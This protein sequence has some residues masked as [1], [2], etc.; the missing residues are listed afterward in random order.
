MSTKGSYD[1]ALQVL[2]SVW[3]MC[4]IAADLRKQL[5]FLYTSCF[6]TVFISFDT[7]RSMVQTSFLMWIIFVLLFFFVG[8]GSALDASW[9]WNVWIRCCEATVDW[10]SWF[11]V[12]GGPWRGKQQMQT[13]F[14]RIYCRKYARYIPGLFLWVCRVIDSDKWQDICDPDLTEHTIGHL[15]HTS[16][17]LD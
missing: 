2:R 4:F 13:S 7:I 10:K 3:K 12:S 14:S 11:T 17:S 5:I 6:L 16:F 9:L 15:C 8:K 1:N